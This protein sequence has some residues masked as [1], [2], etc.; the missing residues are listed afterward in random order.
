MENLGK[1]IMEYYY[2]KI[3]KKGLGLIENGKLEPK[4]IIH[5][6]INQDVF[7][8]LKEYENSPKRELN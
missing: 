3:H 4:E 8:S 7:Y 1:D 6:I 5:F 2:K